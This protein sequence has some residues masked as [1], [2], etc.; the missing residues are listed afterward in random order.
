MN[1]DL[2]NWERLYQQFRTP[3]YIPGYEI[4][5]KLGS[6]AFGVV[7]KARKQSIGKSFAIKFLKVEDPGLREQV[8]RELQTVGLLA[9]VDH[10][11]LVTIEDKGVVDG[12]PYLVMGYAGDE[13]LRTRLQEGPLGTEA[14]VDVFIQACRGVLA[15]H[16]RSIVH[17]DLKPAN[18]FLKGSAVRVGDYGLSKLVADN[19]MTLS[20]VRGTPYY[21]P[22]EVARHKGDHRSDI[23]SLGVI[24]YECL[25]GEV[26]FPGDNEWDV[27]RAHE[28]DALACP[29]MLPDEHREL[30]ERMVAKRP[31]DRFRGLEQV[32]QHMGAPARL[33]ESAKRVVLSP[34]AGQPINAGAA[35]LV[36]AGASWT[37]DARILKEVYELLTGSLALSK[38]T[39]VP[40]EE[41]EDLGRRLE[42]LEAIRHDLPCVVVCGEFKAGKSTLVNALVRRR[43]AAAGVLEMTPCISTIYATGSETCR[44]IESNGRE[45]RLSIDE[46]IGICADRQTA[47]RFPGTIERVEIG[48][49]SQLPFVLVDTPGVGSTTLANERQQLRAMESAD[50][51]LWV[52]DVNALGGLRDFALIDEARRLGMPIWAVL[53]QCD[54][55][56]EE[57]VEGAVDWIAGN[58]GLDRSTIFTCS[59]Q[60]AVD[61]LSAGAP[62]PRSSRVEELGDAI[63]QLTNCRGAELRR[64]SRIAAEGR[65]AVDLLRH[66][67]TFE[68]EVERH[69][70]SLR[71]IETELDAVGDEALQAV[72]NRLLH[73][74]N[75]QFLAPYVD[76][77]DD[78]L[79]ARSPSS[80]KLSQ[81]A[82]LAAL[83]AAIPEDYVTAFWR[84]KLSEAEEFL[85]TRWHDVMSEAQTRIV[86]AFELER[87][88]LLADLG[89]FV[90][91]GAL[92]EMVDVSVVSR[93]DDRTQTGLAIAGLATAYSAWLGPSAASVSLGAAITGVGIPLALL[94]A[95]V[96]WFMNQNDPS[97]RPTS[98]RRSGSAA[99]I[100]NGLREQF[101]VG[102][103]EQHLIPRL[104][105]VNAQ[106]IAATLNAWCESKQGGFDPG[107]LRS[108]LERSRQ[109]R[110]RLGESLSGGATRI[111]TPSEQA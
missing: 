62:V 4:G 56:D 23:Y 110:A 90:A 109:L 18:L 104:H 82:V 67:D 32:L 25:T 35:A 100:I 8:L 13:T 9:E 47:G 14:S 73:A 2:C 94:G 92:S 70:R 1:E 26:P 15:L 77:L 39:L 98:R 63:S 61:A 43:V 16:D 5:N 51:L 83:H 17:F 11:N 101:R 44:V 37:G 38:H 31:E 78:E 72:C 75:E 71:R 41:L 96:A 76:S 6:G 107:S 7:Y 93:L 80:G 91:S 58:H 95:G 64:Q 48:V 106:V 105:E 65:I 34:G 28:E 3:D 54:T 60:P 22:P 52:I 55:V 46:F 30:I 29:Q 84:D 74:V 40:A 50:L 81:K 108:A 10:P 57:S 87:D 12:I 24:F 102:A 79:A 53:S 66:L 85:R 88:V 33:G 45:T 68:A 36:P 49:A 89:R 21:M 19:S 103:L 99:R 27:L 20:G 42:N 86:E 97:P 111:R 59:A 69:E